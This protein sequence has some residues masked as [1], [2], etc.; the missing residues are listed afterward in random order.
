MGHKWSLTRRNYNYV[1]FLFV[2]CSITF[3]ELLANYPQIT[4]SLEKQKCDLILIPSHFDTLGWSEKRELHHISWVNGNQQMTWQRTGKKDKNILPL[5]QETNKP[6]QNS[7][8]PANAPGCPLWR[9]NSH[10]KCGGVINLKAFFPF[11]LNYPELF[12]LSS[13]EEFWQPLR[14]LGDGWL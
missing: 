14:H 13:S 8:L 5:P 6:N 2:L 12:H 3:A 9:K 4:G 10:S 11:P 7:I 1:C